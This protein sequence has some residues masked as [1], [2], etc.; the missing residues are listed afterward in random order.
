MKRVL[1]VLA[2]CS[3]IAL[4][5]LAHKP[6]LEAAV[7][8][9]EELP[10][11]RATI[12]ELEQAVEKSQTAYESLVAIELTAGEKSASLFSKSIQDLWLISDNQLIPGI[13]VNIR[14][15]FKKDPQAAVQKNNRN[16]NYVPVDVSISYD[17]YLGL[18]Y[19]LYTYFLENPIKQL[20][21]TVERLHWRENT[22]ELKINL[23]GE[24]A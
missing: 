15:D 22:V 13:V 19:V 21:I 7:I 1:S 3:G 11:H 2:I 23:Y 9:R 10:E 12:V 8:L 20:P 16:L 4:I 5:G 18:I 17:N 24:L 6:G 14:H